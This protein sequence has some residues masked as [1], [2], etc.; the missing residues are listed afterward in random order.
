MTRALE[1][2]AA[3]YFRHCCLLDAQPHCE[4]GLRKSLYFAQISQPDRAHFAIIYELLDT[5]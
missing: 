5:P 1:V 4:F 2:L 3:F